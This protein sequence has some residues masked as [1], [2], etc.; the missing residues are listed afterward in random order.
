MRTCINLKRPDIIN[1]RC[2]VNRFPA[3]VQRECGKKIFLEHRRQWLVPGS[4][5]IVLI[6]C[7]FTALGRSVTLRGVCKMRLFIIISLGKFIWPHPHLHSVTGGLQINPRSS[8]SFVFNLQM[9][10]IKSIIIIIIIIKYCYYYYI[11]I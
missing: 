5:A 3:Y 1:I 4:V 8:L 9:F 2:M 6:N 7:Q 11:F 10:I